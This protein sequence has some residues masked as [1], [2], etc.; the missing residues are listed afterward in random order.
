[1]QQLSHCGIR[2]RK[3]LQGRLS[4]VGGVVSSSSSYCP[5]RRRHWDNVDVSGSG[6]HG[7]GQSAGQPLAELISEPG[8]TAILVG[9]DDSRDRTVVTHTRD[10][11]GRSVKD[12][13]RRRI[14]TFQTCLA[15]SDSRR[16]ATGTACSQKQIRQG[17]ECIHDPLVSW[18]GPLLRKGQAELV[19]GT[20]SSV[21]R[22]QP[23]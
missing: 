9:R 1:M 17:F 8:G 3:P 5:A 19:P 4:H 22:H 21:M 12:D 13:S 20:I 7:G 15:D 6:S 10:D 2:H 18:F 14:H 23:R 11:R 16:C